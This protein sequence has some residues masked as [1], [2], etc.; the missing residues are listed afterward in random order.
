MSKVKI[1]EERSDDADAGTE[2][3]AAPGPAIS[4]AQQQEKLRDG[5]IW[6]SHCDACGYEQVSPMVR[7]PKCASRDVVGRRFSGTGK[8]VSYTIQ[9]VAP[10]EYMNEVP[11]AF[12]VIQLDD[13]PKV[14]GWVPFIDK[15][16]DLPMGAEV[17]FTS[18]YKPG[19]MFE[20]KG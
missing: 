10:E 19:M 17:E 2:P 4:M 20:K 13:G 11:Y 9:T 1:T 15:A 14:S 8:I 12:A 3:H 7:C 16:A 6:G 18:S 5:E